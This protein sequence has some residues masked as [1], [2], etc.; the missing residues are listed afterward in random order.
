MVGQ[1]KNLW[2]AEEQLFCLI[3][4]D[5]WESGNFASDIMLYIDSILMSAHDI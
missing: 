1:L 5:Q 3:D 2:I 4:F